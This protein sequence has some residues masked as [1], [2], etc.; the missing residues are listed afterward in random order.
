MITRPLWSSTKADVEVCTGTE[1][2]SST[3]QYHRL[4]TLVKIKHAKDFLQVFRHWRCESIALAR[5]VEG[6]NDDGGWGCISRRIMRE[7]DVGCW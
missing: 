5:A 3:G 7:L 4:D 6:D 1:S 2:I